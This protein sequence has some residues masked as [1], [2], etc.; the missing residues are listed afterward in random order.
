MHFFIDRYKEAYKLQLDDLVKLH[1]KNFKPRSSFLDGYEA[2]RLANAA[3]LSV[4]KKTS[5]FI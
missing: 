1:K 3:T 2:L 5:I 4:K